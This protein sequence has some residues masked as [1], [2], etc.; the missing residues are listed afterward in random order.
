MFFNDN[1]GHLDCQSMETVSPQNHEPYLAKKIGLFFGFG[2]MLGL[3]GFITLVGLWGMEKIQNSADAI[4]SDRMAK[5]QLVIQ[6]RAAA[7]ERTVLLERMILL[8]D[9]FERD[10]EFMRFNSHGAQFAQARIALSKSQLS[11][12]E[13][14]LLQQQGKL[15]GVAVPLQ[16]QVVDLL[17]MDEIDRAKQI[18]VEEAIPLQDQVLQRLT[19][20][21]DYQQQQANQAA[22]EAGHANQE[23][24]IWMLLLSAVAGA[25]GI[26]IAVVVGRRTVQAQREREKYLDEIKRANE[27]KSAFLA[28][29][30]H[31]I[32]T[33]LTAIIGFADASLDGDHTAEERQN[34]FR[35]IVRSGKHLLQII[36]D[37]LDLSKVEADKLE[38]E[39]IALSPFQ[40]LAEVDGLV[41]MQAV[42]KGLA[43][44][45]EHEFPLPEKIASDPIRI[46]QVLINLCGNAI[47]FTHSGHVN[48]RVSY[49]QQAQLFHF[50]VVDSGIGLNKEQINRIF[51]AFI[52]ADSSTTRKYG[53]TGLGLSLSRRLAQMLGGSLE[54]ISEPGIGSSFDFTVDPGPLNDVRMINNVGEIVIHQE[55]PAN[56]ATRNY[57]A[58]GK[59]LL[60]EDTLE[61]QTLL[62]LYLRKTGAQVHVVENGQLAV[63]AARQE[64]FDLIFMDMQMPVMDGLE[65]VRLLRQHGYDRPIVALTANAMNA[66]KQRCLQAG[67]DDFISKPVDREQLL[68][69]TARY[70][71]AKPCDV[72]I[73][74]IYSTLTV[75]DADFKTLVAQ[76][77]NRLPEVVDEIVVAVE[78]QQWEK[79]RFLAHKLRGSGGGYGFPQLTEIASKLSYQVNNENFWELNQ[80]VDEL[81]TLCRRIVAG[82]ENAKDTESVQTQ[83]QALQQ[84]R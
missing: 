50:T 81:K 80:L 1:R 53:G 32:R 84:I 27:A 69:V 74:P 44:N 33:P 59:I 21:Y 79:V 82:I 66:D 19:Q 14:D 40:L 4:V 58:E 62:S 63:E 54:V 60:A 26:M 2:A 71:Q 45:I 28:N 6:M 61:N 64:Q 25:I 47:K 76:Y 65:A 16:N 70:L 5:I 68:Q 17:A 11:E 29:M 41:R 52:Q 83:A 55:T 39:R 72:Q 13:R 3:M 67:C 48:I 35:T 36:N 23:A 42:E 56:S 30:S 12:T 7:R 43:F 77:V 78:Q 10:A 18:L 75:E 24:R 37:I 20:L 34:A 38:V 73:D 31:E 49:D 8:D 15:S 9:P 57:T 51:C 46:K 22:A